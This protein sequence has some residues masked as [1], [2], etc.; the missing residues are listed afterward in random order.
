MKKFL[1]WEENNHT[2]IILI[3]SKDISIVQ[4]KLIVLERFENVIKEKNIFLQHVFDDFDEAAKLV[5]CQR[6][7]SFSTFVKLVLRCFTTDL[8][9][10]ITKY[11]YTDEMLTPGKIKQLC[12]K[13]FGDVK[14][15][16]NER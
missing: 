12:L 9:E 14:H 2:R 16:G 8:Y 6:L 10:I 3:T 1:N 7:S 13:V 11:M 15:M 4:A 5:A